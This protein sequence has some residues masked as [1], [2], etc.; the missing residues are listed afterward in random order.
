[1]SYSPLLSLQV[2]GVRKQGYLFKKSRKV[3][4]NKPWNVRWFVLSEDGFLQWYKSWKVRKAKRQR[5]KQRDREREKEERRDCHLT[6]SFT[7]S[8]I[9]ERAHQYASGCRQAL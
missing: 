2:A 6:L 1:M 8:D 5:G 4:S 3:L 9:E 7:E